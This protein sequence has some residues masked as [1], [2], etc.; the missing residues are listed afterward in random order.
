MADWYST[1]S[2]STQAEAIRNGACLS[3]SLCAIREDTA[4]GRRFFDVDICPKPA[5]FT[6]KSKFVR[7]Y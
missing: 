5:L 4:I 6:R 2:A 7:L 1:L 3:Q